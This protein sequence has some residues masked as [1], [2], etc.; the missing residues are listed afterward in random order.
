MYNL[1]IKSYKGI[2]LLYFL[3]IHKRYYFPVYSLE[4]TIIVSEMYI[5]IKS[6]YERTA[7]EEINQ[8]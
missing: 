2:F 6:D 1:Y 5:H 4:I 8:M 7:E 3:Y